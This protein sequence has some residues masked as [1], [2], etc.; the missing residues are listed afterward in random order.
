M[1]SIYEFW[2]VS[3]IQ[4]KTLLSLESNVNSNL[5]TAVDAIADSFIHPVWL[6]N[7]PWNEETRRKQ[8]AHTMMQHR[9]KKAI[10]IIFIQNRCRFYSYE[11]RSALVMIVLFLDAF[12]YEIFSRF[13][14][15]CCYHL[16]SFLDINGKFILLFVCATFCVNIYSSNEQKSN[17]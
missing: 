8:H 7:F 6:N 14:Q 4:F 10:K 5:L 2:F 1:H 12:I 15:C 9:F 3:A 11:S 17:D 13:L 16:V